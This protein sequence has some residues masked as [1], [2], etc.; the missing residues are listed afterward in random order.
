M[1]SNMIN[2]MMKLG[3]TLN[4]SKVYLSIIDFGSSK[5][6]KI[7]KAV[8]IERSSCYQSLN[9][10]V[11][12]GL[13]SYVQIGKIKFFQ[14]ASPKRF[15]ERIK[16]QEEIANSIIPELC[17]RHKYKKKEGEVWLF[18]G[19]KG[20]KSVLMDIISVGKMNRIFGGEG[21]LEERLPAFKNAFVK[22]L[23]E[24]RIKI[25]ELIR[26]DR[27]DELQF[28]REVKLFPSKVKSPVVTNI[29]GEKIAIIIWT[30]EPEA[31]IIDN[32]AAAASYRS[33]FDFMWE[34]AKTK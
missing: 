24:K 19:K 30:D 15:L 34:N 16:E 17:E 26:N 27:E 8:S 10:L 20:V 12:K 25:K 6:G 28:N 4:E 32:K 22:E 3:L 2:T 23:K 21:Q 1:V 9:S 33:I 14:A 7:A 29:Y 11:N 18:K 31:I 13:V 5:A